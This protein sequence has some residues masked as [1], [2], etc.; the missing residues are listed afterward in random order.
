MLE[1]NR[2]P[3]EMYPVFEEAGLPIDRIRIAMRLDMDADAVRCDHWLLV[4]DEEMVLLSGI[5]LIRPRRH[6]PGRTPHLTVVY[7]HLN[8]RRYPLSGCTRL[9]VEDLIGTS[10]LI[11]SY[12]N[13]DVLLSYLT[14]SCRSNASRL[15]KCMEFVLRGEEIPEHLQKRDRAVCPKCGTPYPDPHRRVCP[16]CSGKGKLIRRML[17][18]IM[19]YK[20]AVLLTLLTLILSSGL[21]VLSPYISSG[22]YYDQVLDEAGEFYGQLLLVIGIIAAVR[23]LS[24]LVNLL[25]G[26]ISSSLSARI[27]YDLKK[28]IFSSIQRLSL[29]FFTNRQTG[30]LM[31]QVNGDAN[32]IYWFFVDGLPYLLVNLTQCIAILIIMFTM[33]V[34]LTAVSMCVV[35][36]VAMT[37]LALMRRMRKYHAKRYARRR[38]MN[39]TLS[40]SLT[41]IRVV[42]AFAKEEAET[43][44]FNQRSRA[45]ADI[46]Q[47]TSLFHNIAFPAAS[48]I[49]S[50]SSLIVWAF[51][52]WMVIQGQLSYGLLLTFVSYV[53]MIYG[54]INFFVDMIYTATDCLNAMQRLFEVM[55]MTPDVKESDS[56]TPLPECRGEV[57]FEN[58]SFSYEKNRKIIDGVSFTVAPG[59]MLGI[60]GHTGAGKSTLANLLIR[61]YD[62]G[63]G[64]I[65]IDGIDVRDLAFSD[66]RRH[67]AIV[68]QETYLFSGTV[69]ENIRYARPD[70]TYEEVLRA[71]HIAGAHDFISRMPDGYDTK[72]GFGH[73]D[74][75]GGERQRISIA[76]A[77]LR[78]PQILI[79]DEA[80]A[81]MDT[82]TER[83]IQ[84]A[85]ERLT[86]NRTTIVIAHRLSTLRNADRLIVI[87]NGK[88]PESGTHAELI[89]QKG[90]YYKL[91]MLQMEA[92]KS[93]GIQA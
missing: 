38:S 51:G 80:T 83:K 30:G 7:Q 20:F 43:E 71:A 9:S 15:V 37:F 72:V 12:E 10:R 79:L 21:S 53:G 34:S 25:T 17:P 31:T 92:L 8:D 69:L 82:E 40:D 45:L 85:I 19:R 70:A 44:R 77:V 24:L 73:Q 76:R 67:V 90:L 13:E 86:E 66:L 14:A 47:K 27:V 60:V 88:M 3:R 35:P 91:Y 36:V 4:T 63:E 22:F 46:E 6:R 28:T 93:A 59:Q 74:L 5:R 55:D 84:A 2:I 49:L 52:G 87:E 50:L 64:C 41:G 42:K 29:S 23:V 75:S 48:F 56:P 81:A 11:A 89:R 33:Q 58:V 26:V 78:D 65:R 57:C 54:P 68:S 32:S 61:L 1:I 39:A 62:A 16:A 18:F